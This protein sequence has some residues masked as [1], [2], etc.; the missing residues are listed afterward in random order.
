[1]KHGDKLLSIPLYDPPTHM[2][3]RSTNNYD[4]MSRADIEVIVESSFWLGSPRTSVGTFE[5]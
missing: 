2:Y 3:S 5:D 1:M 4:S